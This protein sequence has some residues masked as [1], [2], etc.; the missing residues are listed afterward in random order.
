[1]KLTH[2]V[3]AAAQVWMFALALIGFIGLLFVLVAGQ[4]HLDATTEK[5]VY[6]MLGV[7]GAIVTQMTSYFFSRQR[8]DSAPQPQ[9]STSHDAQNAPP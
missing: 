9:P 5:L 4:A 1:M 3:V 6:A 8:P 7:F 2:I